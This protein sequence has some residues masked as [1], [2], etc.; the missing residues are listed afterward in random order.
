[1]RKRVLYNRCNANNY[2]VK[3]DVFFEVV[4]LR[5]FNVGRHT[6][7]KNLLFQY[8]QKDSSYEL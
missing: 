3:R 4:N 8:G 1:M 5:F 7:C 2:S 6:I